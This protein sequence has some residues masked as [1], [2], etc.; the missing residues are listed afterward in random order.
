MF[1]EFMFLEFVQFVQYY[2]NNYFEKYLR[3]KAIVRNN[4]TT[5]GVYTIVM[6]LLIAV[7]GIFCCFLRHYRSMRDSSSIIEYTSS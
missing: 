7:G 2:N 6:I 3:A 5:L 4:Y 1:L